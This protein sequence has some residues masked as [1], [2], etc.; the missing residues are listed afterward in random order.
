MASV[1]GQY[2]ER[3]QR[4]VKAGIAAWF[5]PQKRRTYHRAWSPALAHAHANA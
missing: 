2:V 5:T 4:W 1:L 3:W